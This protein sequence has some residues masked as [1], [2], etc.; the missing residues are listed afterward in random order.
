MSNPM[1]EKQRAKQQKSN[2]EKLDRILANLPEAQYE[3][4]EPA[5]KEKKN[6]QTPK[7]ENKAQR[8][9]E[10]KKTS[11]TPKQKPEAPKKNPP[12]KPVDAEKKNSGWNQKKRGRPTKAA[13]NPPLK[14]IPLGGLGE[15]GRNMAVFEIDGNTLRGAFDGTWLSI[16]GHPVAYYYLNTVESEDGEQYVITGY[17][18]ALLNGNQ[19]RL[20]LVF[21]NERPYGYIAGAQPVYTNG[22]PQ[23]IAKNLIEV[24]AGD[25]VVFLYDYYTRDHEYQQTMKLD[26]GITLGKN[27]EI[28]NTPI[29]NDFAPVASYCFTDTYQ[30]QYWT[31]A[32][33]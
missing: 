10:N 19:V 4:E 22:E 27:V 12:K 23:T 33:P 14:I 28:S 21:D 8:P 17:V 18:P 13:N 15:I 5:K 25:K 3:H 24:G 29:G 31:P 26:N 16:D 32:I 20:I 2:L 11:E 9:A 30:V 1:T 6:K 7:K